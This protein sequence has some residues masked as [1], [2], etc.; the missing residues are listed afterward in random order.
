MTPHEQDLL[1][2][3]DDGMIERDYPSRLTLGAR[4]RPRSNVPWEGE[5][6]ALNRAI[7]PWAY[8]VRWDHGCAEP[9]ACSASELEVLS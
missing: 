3:D 2:A 9:E 1:R 7:V 6:I 8:L 4:V 5:V